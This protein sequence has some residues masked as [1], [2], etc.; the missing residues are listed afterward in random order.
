MSDLDAIIDRNGRMSNARSV[1]D[2]IIQKHRGKLPAIL[3]ELWQAQGVGDWANGLFRT[4]IPGDF[5]G[6]LSQIFHADSEFSHADC[7]IFAYTVFGTVFAWSERHGLIRIDLNRGE[8]IANELTKKR[9]EGRKEDA[10]TALLFRLTKNDSLDAYDDDDKKLYSRAVK[11]LGRPGI[12]QAFG[13]FPALA[14]GGAPRLENLRIVPALEHFLFLAQLQPF[15]LVDYL[16][17]PPQVIR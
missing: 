16:T 17:R 7:Y 1:P 12:G 10:V 4:C 3:L 6:L 15:R 11:K 2:Q 9:T 8:V 14:M 13:F 5:D